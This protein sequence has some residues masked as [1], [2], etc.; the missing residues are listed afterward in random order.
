MKKHLHLLLFL[1]FT[2]LFGAS[3]HAQCDRVGWVASVMPGCG[4]RIIDLDN[5]QTLRAVEGADGLSGGQIF[6]FNAESTVLPAGCSSGNFP[7]VA[8]T[9]VSAQLPC[10]A[11]FA[12]IP[13]SENL[14]TYKLVAHLYDASAQECFWDFGDGATATGAIVEHTYADEGEYNVC[15]TVTDA[16]GCQVQT[17]QSLTATKSDYNWCGFDIQVTAVGT[18]LQ[19]KLIPNGNG[20]SLAD[21]DS[22]QWYTNKSSQVLSEAPAFN[23][24]LPEYGT[25]TICATY[26]VVDPFD[27]SVCRASQCRT[28]TLAELECIN[29]ML[30]DPSQL[31]PSE[32]QLN[33]PVCGCDG[34]T[35]ANECEVLSAGVSKWW[36][37]ACGSE[38]GS[39]VTKMEAQILSGS[40]G[41]GYLAQFINHSNGNFSFAQLDFGDGSPLWEGVLWDTI[42]HLYEA[43]G[44]YKANLTVWN[45]NGCISSVTQLIVTDAATMSA[46]TLP[47]VT[48]Y[49]MPGDAN[50]DQRA[51]VYDLLNLGVGHFNAGAPRPD[52]HTNW[53][54]QFAPNWEHSLQN[55]T[56]Y[57]HFDCDG[58]GVVN[59]LDADV[60]SL[61]Y[62][63]ID[64]TYVPVLPQ[65]PPLRLEFDGDTLVVDPNNPA[66]V[67]ITASLRLGS[68][69]RPALGLYG[70]AFALKYPEYVNHNPDVDYDDDLFGSTNHLLWLA[71]DVH[72]REQL[73][74]GVTRK[75]GQSVNGYGRI[76]KITFAVDYIIIIDVI[77]RGENKAIPFVVP[78]RGIKAIDNKGNKFEIT[79]PVERDTIWIK[80]LQTTKTQ[81]DLLQAKVQLSPNPASDVATLYTQDLD[82]ASIE[83][84]NSLGQKIQEVPSTNAPN[85]PINVSDWTSGVYALRIFTD[86][87]LVEKKLVVK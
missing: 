24:L 19:G 23:A 52:A 64:T 36:A 1:G 46:E 78:I 62:K 39:C 45:S 87:G 48:D 25:Y 74:I 61:H 82:I 12:R 51:N 30:S 47:A 72:A 35:Y 38:L 44:I 13:V 42:I 50:R 15:L 29:P 57:K 26:K 21:I 70:L 37:G 41:T 14:L 58:N 33:A 2:G 31:C 16:F 8:L 40:P 32:T 67:Q 27:G 20:I 65:A 63:A 83:V 86:Q 84:I 75:N 53:I 6:S 76:A 55:N 3:A 66:P 34:I 69:S 81:E 56:N 59:E 28:I 77:E 60:I 73:D 80:V 9:C 85:T 18:E 11:V 68:P 10:K 49:V 5:G 7:V 71:K 4:A 17:C 54:P 22:V 79:V 43:G